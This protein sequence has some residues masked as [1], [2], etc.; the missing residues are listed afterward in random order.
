MSRHALEM[1][2][3]KLSMRLHSPSDSQPASTEKKVRKD[4]EKDFD[5]TK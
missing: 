5:L 4:P 2:I 3:L 1:Q